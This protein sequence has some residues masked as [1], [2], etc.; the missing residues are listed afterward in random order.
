M[1]KRRFGVCFFSTETTETE[2]DEEKS[3]N[4]EDR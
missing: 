4:K 2:T 1:Y 3:N